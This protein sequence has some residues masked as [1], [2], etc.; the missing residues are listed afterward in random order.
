MF[1]GVRG[2]VRAPLRRCRKRSRTCH[3]ARKRRNRFAVDVPR[4]RARSVEGGCWTVDRGRL[5]FSES[6]RTSHR[7][8]RRRPR[9]RPT[10]TRSGHAPA[11][12]RADRT[13]MNGAATNSDPSGNRPRNRVR[14]ASSMTSS[15]KSLGCPCHSFVTATRADGTRQNTTRPAHRTA[16]R[17]VDRYES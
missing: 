16:N 15:D 8:P 1:G 14:S 6:D 5:R 13:V 9:A 12:R 11:A 10:A 3:G 4:R 7:C 17:L 2:N